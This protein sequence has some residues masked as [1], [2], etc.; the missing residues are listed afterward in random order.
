M[1][2]KPTLEE[3][4]KAAEQFGDVGHD[5]TNLMSTIAKLHMDTEFEMLKITLMSLVT[6]KR[7][8]YSRFGKD[9]KEYKRQSILELKE[10]LN[11]KESD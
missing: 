10:M 11:E 2:K 6:T 5:I 3:Y 1:S 7:R 9:Y 8:F 4:V